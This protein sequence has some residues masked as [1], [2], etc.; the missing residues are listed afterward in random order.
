VVTG[1]IAVLASIQVGTPHRYGVEGAPQAI[2][3]AWTTSFFREPSPVKRWL[4]TTHLEGNAQADTR[5]HGRP[6][7]AVLL[8]AEAHYA[9]W[10]AELGRPELGPG[11]FGENFTMAGLIEETAC[12]GDTYGIGEARV[13]V[14]G[15]RYPCWKIERRWRLPGLT[16]RVAATGRTGW[17]CRVLREGEVAPGM[18][19]TLLDRPYPAFT[20]ALVN[21]FGHCRGGDETVARA[22]A[23][24]PLLN[25]WWRDLV[26]RRAGD[27]AV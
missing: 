21:D 6:D 3:R 26:L 12:I 22:L 17:Y 16:D 14:S 13:Q 24:C 15:P 20:V 4:F 2:D 7:Q 19:V 18:P 9:L 8:Y 11:G 5:N 25:E 23:A 1:Q 10:R 27:E